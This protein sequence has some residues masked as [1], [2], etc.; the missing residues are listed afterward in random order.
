M[1]F[2]SVCQALS[3]NYFQLFDSANYFE[4]P[5]AECY[6][7]LVKR[8]LEEGRQG[9]TKSLQAFVFRESESWTYVTWLIEQAKN[10]PSGGSWC[11][12]WEEFRDYIKDTENEINALEDTITE[13]RKRDPA[14]TDLETQSL[15]QKRDQLSQALDT[16]L[17]RGYNTLTWE[18]EQI[19]RSSMHLYGSRVSKRHPVYSWKLATSHSFYRMSSIFT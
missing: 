10:N 6:A 16:R 3:G 19:K 18:M 15:I 2:T 1:S 5:A 17:S 12:D 4:P 8:L 9:A 13:K 11:R 14:A 7:G